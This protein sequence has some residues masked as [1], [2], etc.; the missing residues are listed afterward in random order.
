[1]QQGMQKFKIPKTS[2]QKTKCAQYTKTPLPSL[3]RSAYYSPL[4]ESYS[5][6]IRKLSG[7]CS[8]PKDNDSNSSGY[9]K[10]DLCYDQKKNRIVSDLWLSTCF[11]NN[12]HPARLF[13]V[14]GFEIK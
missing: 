9:G 5:E 7:V 3:L 8:I 4:D 13:N 6:Q 10:T 2:S 12:L 11:W 14:K 1:M